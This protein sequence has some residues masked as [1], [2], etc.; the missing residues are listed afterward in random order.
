MVGAGGQVE[1]IAGDHLNANPLV[2]EGGADVE[3][4]GAGESEAHFGIRVQMLEEEF[5]YLH[6]SHGELEK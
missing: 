1:Q 2:V 5:V 4:A 3:V 6:A